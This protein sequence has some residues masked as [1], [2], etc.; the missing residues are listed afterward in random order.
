MIAGPSKANIFMARDPF[1]DYVLRIVLSE[2]CEAFSSVFIILFMKQPN[3][4]CENGAKHSPL[5]SAFAI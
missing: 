2:W 3:L 5:A 4:T 1:N